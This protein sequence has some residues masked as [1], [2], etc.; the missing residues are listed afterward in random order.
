M[1]FADYNEFHVP[2]SLSDSECA[3]DE[4]YGALMFRKN[5]Y[6][7]SRV[8]LSI[9]GVGVLAVAG[10]LIVISG[11]AGK[12]PV[13][14]PAPVKAAGNAKTPVTDIQ[15]TNAG[16][17]E[18]STDEEDEQ[19]T[20]IHT[21]DDKG[22]TTYIS[23]KKATIYLPGK[24]KRKV[25]KIAT[26]TGRRMKPLTEKKPEAVKLVHPALKKGKGK[27]KVGVQ[28]NAGGGGEGG[29]GA[30]SS[31]KGKGGEAGKGKGPGSAGGGGTGGK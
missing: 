16:E 29:G 12:E 22:K 11:D 25:F 26:A 18:V 23:M 3:Q 14:P 30:T 2:G 7:I 28:G 19:P 10:T 1:G 21:V 24:G 31:D 27:G 5:E 9:L 17:K 20:L 13:K 4:R 15:D 8:V 6:G